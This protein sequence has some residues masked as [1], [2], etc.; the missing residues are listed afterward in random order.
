M[1]IDSSSRL[2]FSLMVRI[3]NRWKQSEKEK[4][5]AE[6]SYFKAQ[7]NPHFLF[8]T[9]NSI[10]SLAIQKEEN[11][12]DA[13]VKL[14][15]LMRYVISDASHDFVTLDKEIS[16]INDYIEL[17]KLRYGQTVEIDYTPCNPRPG[18]MIAPLLLIPFIENA[19][20]YGINPESL[21]RIEITMQLKQSELHLHVYNQKAFSRDDSEAVGGLGMKNT[22]QRLSL[23]YPD[24]Q[25]LFIENTKTDFTVDL[26]IDL[27]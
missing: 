11:T 9:L 3:H 8:N 25:K 2:D 16:Y 18:M 17:Q 12:A 22:R 23:L 19:F 13:I 26:Y 7:I 6:L 24:K 10:Y 20:K 27:G 14:S 21:S 5:K 15:G 4:L 1:K